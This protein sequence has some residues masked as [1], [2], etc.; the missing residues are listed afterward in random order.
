MKSLGGSC[1]HRL[2]QN[3]VIG[4]LLWR[5]AIRKPQLICIFHLNMQLWKPRKKSFIYISDDT[6][7]RLIALKESLATYLQRIQKRKWK[8]LSETQ[9]NPKTSGIIGQSLQT[10][11]EHMKDDAQKLSIKLQE[12]KLTGL[13]NRQ[14]LQRGA[15]VGRNCRTLFVSLEMSEWEEGFRHEIS[16]KGSATCA[17]KPD[18]LSQ[19]EEDCEISTQL[20]KIR[21]W[22]TYYSA[23]CC[24]RTCFIL[25]RFISI[26][27]F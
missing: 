22:L 24:L 2:K 27:V 26:H 8:F 17:Y 9:G 23:S 11:E 12:G 20:P 7:N 10:P 25:R 16:Y 15:T 3:L 19:E 18:A 5:L 4:N 6:L 1:V 21:T 13:H 14:D